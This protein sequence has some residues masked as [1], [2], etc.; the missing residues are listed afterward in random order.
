MSDIRRIQNEVTA[1]VLHNFG[2]DNEL[3]TVGG[4]I[5]EAGEVMQAA[6]KRSQG[7]RGTRE[8]WDAKLRKESA[9]VFIKLCD[10]AQF[11]G[12]D[13]ADAIAERWAVVKLRDWK[14]NP[15]GHGIGAA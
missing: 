8:E 15:Q 2:N 6:V 5:E 4:L 14:A 3:A 12:F 10:V 13:L 11:N 7:I 1:W 9:D